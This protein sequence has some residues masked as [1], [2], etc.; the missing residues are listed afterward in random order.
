MTDY[1]NSTKFLQLTSY[2]APRI[3]ESSGENYVEWTTQN[4]ENYFKYIIDR[5]HGSPTNNAIIQTISD[6]IYGKGLDATNKVEN[7][8]D[9][10]KSLLLFKANEIRKVT[11]DFKMF[12]KYAFQVIYT[13]DRNEIAEIWHAPVNKYMPER[14]NEDGDIEAYYYS[15]DWSDNNI[16]PKRIPAFGF[17]SKELNEID[18]PECPMEIFYFQPY[19]PGTFYF[20]PVDYQGGLQYAE[21]EEQIADFHLNNLENGFHDLTIINFNNGIPPEEKQ[22]EIER[23]I[24]NK[25]SGTHGQRVVVS[26]NQDKETAPTIESAGIQDADK[27]FDLLSKESTE[28][29]MRSHRITSPMLLGIKDNT[30]LG[31]NADELK[32][33]YLL[34]QSMVVQ[35]YQD[36]IIEGIQQLAVINGIHLDYFMN[37][38]RPL[39]FATDEAQAQVTDEQ[40]QKEQ[41]VEGEQ[42]ESEVEVNEHLKNLS[43]KQQQQL[44]RIVRKFNKGDL[45]ELQAII[46]LKSSFGFTEE[47]AKQYLGLDIT[48]LSA[49]KPFL[50]DEQGVLIAAKAKELGEVISD[51]WELYSEEKVEDSE[52]E[53]TAVKLFSQFADADNK[54]TQDRGLFK[55]RY[56]YAPES[57]NADSRQFCKDMVAL[58]TQGL[59]YRKEDIDA[60]SSA[61]VNGQFSEKG[62]STYDIFK[63]KGGAYCHHYWMRRIYMRKRNSKGAFLP[64]EGLENDK[65]V[66]V[67]EARR[68][69]VPIPT[70]SKD[71]ATRPI[72]MPKGGKL[73]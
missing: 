41:G 57:A 32:T 2:V 17:G 6:L 18:E 25:W 14:C 4:G 35:P 11:H 72:D 46:Q 13:K 42:L 52:T 23:G 43:G 68:K 36:C 67:N 34:M 40:I 65:K 39:E 61:G 70:N 59:V 10:A 31:N 22:S 58:A 73:N 5:Y 71:V 37:P 49:Y 69:G 44:D 19:S 33:A 28:K 21:M 29:L 60:M 12:N 24:K 50:D 20:S 51:E 16:N 53:L 63:F 15:A 26:F 54:S 27:L 9:W 3:Q 64:N 7:T 8:K 45:T 30:G 55:I 56:A 47:L 38:L 66:S 48:T 1:K 62:K